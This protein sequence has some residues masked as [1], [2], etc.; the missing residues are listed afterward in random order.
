MLQSPALLAPSSV[1]TTELK[2]APHKESKR[3][4][5]SVEYSDGDASDSHEGRRV[6]SRISGA[7]EG[8]SWAKQK[9]LKAKSKS[10]D[11][12]TNS[13]KYKIFKDKILKDDRRAKFKTTNTCQVWCS[14]CMKW[15]EMRALYDTLRWTD[16]RGGKA[17]LKRQASG[18]SQQQV[19]DF[20]TA[21]STKKKAS[22]PRAETPPEDPP[23]PGLSRDK[24]PLVRRYLLRAGTRGGGAPSRHNIAR[25]F[26]EE[27]LG[28]EGCKWKN[29]SGSRQKV[30]LHR[31]ETLYEWR[32]L[33]SLGT[34][35]STHCTGLASA[36]VEPCKRCSGLLSLHTFQNRLNAKMPKEENMKFV[37]K[38]FRQT[39]L[40]EIYLNYKGVRQLV[41]AVRLQFI[42]IL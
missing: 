4:H 21:P 1:I 33:H 26:W 36:G 22:K 25:S 12:E 42:Y 23:C 29:L 13:A 18:L 8:S 14:A 27:K 19:A 39:E 24:F 5:T 3:P 7:K 38:A 9:A 2:K 10:S 34:V 20:F 11:F 17:C 31:E 41:E 35:V 16:H 32:N 30:V 6:R 15:V 40:G 37:P 28:W